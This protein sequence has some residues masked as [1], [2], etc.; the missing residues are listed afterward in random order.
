ML[1]PLLSWH[2]FKATKKIKRIICHSYFIYQVTSHLCV[3]L[4]TLHLLKSFKLIIDQIQKLK[5]QWLID[6]WLL[7]ALSYN[8]IL[9]T[10]FLKFTLKIWKFASNEFCNFF[11]CEFP[12]FQIKLLFLNIEVIIS[13]YIH[14]YKDKKSLGGIIMRFM[15]LRQ[16]IAKVISWFYASCRSSHLI[17]KIF[18]FK[19]LLYLWLFLHFN[20][21]LRKVNIKKWNDEGI[22]NCFVIKRKF[23]LRTKKIQL[24]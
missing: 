6:F 18:E 10:I 7:N 24:E 21:I 16:H 11:S 17:I 9:E 4:F 23:I 13:G 22:K 14:F 5:F 20:H 19:I 1:L 8:N 3:H 15:I 2:D 12:L